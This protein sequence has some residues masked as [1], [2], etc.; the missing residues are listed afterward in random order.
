MA[1]KFFLD[2]YSV[3][4]GLLLTDSWTSLKVK[5][6]LG[7]VTVTVVKGPTRTKFFS[8]VQNNKHATEQAD[9]NSLCPPAPTSGGQIKIVECKPFAAN[10][11]SCV[12]F[13]IFALSV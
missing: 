8:V 7:D 10:T 4:L 3:V 2:F 9:L 12:M 1:Q 13:E 5:G 11:A 6:L